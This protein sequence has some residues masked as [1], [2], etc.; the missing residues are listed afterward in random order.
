M[1]TLIKMKYYCEFCHYETNKKFNY[2]MHLKS[3]KHLK[4]VSLNQNTPNPQRVYNL[5]PHNNQHI[6]CDSCNL[7][8]S[9]KD[10]LARHKKTCIALKLNENKLKEK[11]KNTK[12]E[13]EY[14]KTEVEYYKELLMESVK[15]GKGNNIIIMVNNHF[16]D[17]NQLMPPQNN[18]LRIF[19]VDHPKNAS[20]KI[21]YNLIE[22]ANNLLVDS[23]EPQED[24]FYYDK[25]T[26]MYGLGRDRR[27]D[28]INREKCKI[29]L[30]DYIA[31]GI[32]LLYKTK[33]PEEQAFWATDVARYNF[34]LKNEK[35]KSDK[36]GEKLKETLVTTIL[37]DINIRIKRQ[38]TRETNKSIDYTKNNK[39][40]LTGF[41]HRQ[42]M[43]DIPRASYI[44]ED[45][46]S[47]SLGSLIIKKV[48]KYF[49]VDKELLF[50]LEYL[51][52]EKSVDKKLITN[53]DKNKNKKKFKVIEMSEEDDV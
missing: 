3:K 29:A 9:R 19:G 39:R 23:K 1:N 43:R 46:E 5:P 2:D 30:A 35:W 10:S 31:S 33:K 6:I 51:G 41:V 36:N 24:K 52:K 18:E 4:K 27:N 7:S 32:R 42:I 14:L 44:I 26:E 48:A 47:G 16:G 45:I 50:D 38:L 53:K 20:Y 25:V 28:N 21:K 15:G 37:D 11:L 40:K 13:N 34:I 22:Q 49:K 8:F 17:A 12:K